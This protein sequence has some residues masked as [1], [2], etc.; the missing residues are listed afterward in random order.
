MLSYLFTLISDPPTI[1]GEHPYLQA[2]QLQEQEQL[3]TGT[4]ISVL[5]RRSS[6]QQSFFLLFLND[7]ALI[8]APFLNYVSGFSNVALVSYMQ[9]ALLIRSR[10]RLIGMDL[11]PQEFH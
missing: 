1:T 5:C 3:G 11:R 7:V 8:N 6:G 10:R 2:C 9:Y 4:V